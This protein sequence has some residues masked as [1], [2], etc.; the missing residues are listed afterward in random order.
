MFFAGRSSATA[1]E[2]TALLTQLVCALLRQPLRRFSRLLLLVR[3]AQAAFLKAA[4]RPASRAGLL[5]FKQPNKQATRQRLIEAAKEREGGRDGNYTLNP[6]VTPNRT[7]P[8]NIKT[9]STPTC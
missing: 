3:P 2:E 5:L 4:A 7:T 6:Y 1:F 9:T 8:P